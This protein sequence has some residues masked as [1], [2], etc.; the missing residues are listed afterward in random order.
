MLEIGLLACSGIQTFVSPWGKNVKLNVNYCLSAVE[1][2]NLC[3]ECGGYICFNGGTC[4]ND[5]CQ[6]SEGFGGDFCQYGE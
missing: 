4:V 1:N 5:T 3:K 2:E 6:C